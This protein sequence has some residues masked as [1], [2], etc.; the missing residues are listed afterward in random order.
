MES[1][2]KKMNLRIRGAELGQSQRSFCF[3]C[4]FLNCPS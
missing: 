2:E 1:G 4:A 3:D